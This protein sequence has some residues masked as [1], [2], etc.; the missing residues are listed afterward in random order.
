[1]EL[2]KLKG[3]KW[4]DAE[5]NY[6]IQNIKFNAKGFVANAKEVSNGLGFTIAQVQSKIKRLRDKGELPCPNRTETYCM[7]EKYSPFAR[8]RIAAMHRQGSTY[9]EMADS[10]GRSKSGIANMINKMRKM[11][12]ISNANTFVW[13]SER[14]KK[15][16]S[17]LIFDDFGCIINVVELA[18]EFN[19]PKEKIHSKIERLRKKGVI[20][21]PVDRHSYLRYTKRIKLRKTI[22][23]EFQLRRAKRNAK[24]NRSHAINR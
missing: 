6:L 4:T 21:R 10:L 23:N 11:G 2:I 7:Y 9:Q 19:I 5:T 15:L 18:R 20:S 12:Q 24:E 14:E 8:K 3:H 13:N 17:A 22:N 16:L 1:M